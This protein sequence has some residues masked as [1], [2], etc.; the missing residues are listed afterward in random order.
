MLVVM[1]CK[2]SKEITTFSPTGEWKL[3]KINGKFVS[4]IKPIT[5]NFNTTEQKVSGFAGCNQYFGNFTADK[6]SLKFSLLGSTKMYC[7]SMEIENKFLDILTQI[8]SF[9]SENNI[10]ILLTDQQVILDSKNNYLR[11]YCEAF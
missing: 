6:T 2:V 9:S 8:N 7:D 5:L 1:G 11:G 4:L 3:S 10:L